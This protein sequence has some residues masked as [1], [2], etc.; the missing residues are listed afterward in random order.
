MLPVLPVLDVL[1]PKKNKRLQILVAQPACANNMSEWKDALYSAAQRGLVDRVATLLADVNMQDVAVQDAMRAAL[2]ISIRNDH[3]IVVRI[4]C[5]AGAG[6]KLAKHG[7]SI[8]FK[9]RN[10]RCE[11]RHNFQPIHLAASVGSASCIAELVSHFHISAGARDMCMDAPLHWA[12]RHAHVDAIR[13][14]L[15]VKAHIGD[16]NARHETP[17]DLAVGYKH[18][19]GVAALVAS[20]SEETDVST[21]FQR[22]RERALDNHCFTLVGLLTRALIARHSAVRDRPSVTHIFF[23]MQSRR[24]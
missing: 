18:N 17:L 14:L 16:K 15:V 24:K 10:G 23:K 6:F 1:S 9:Y 3:V 19:R 7:F 20:Q 5:A 2:Q 8:K 12:C 21:V 11:L 13:K 4:L 22:A